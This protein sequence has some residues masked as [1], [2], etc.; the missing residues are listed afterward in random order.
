MEKMALDACILRGMDNIFYL[1]GFRGSE[2]T[3]VITRNNVILI[4]DFRYI[5]HAQQV[6]SGIEIAEMKHRKN[7]LADI[8]TERGIKTAGFDSLHM[9]YNLYRFWESSLDGVRLIPLD[10]VIEEIRVL[11]EPEEIRAIMKAISVA[12]NAFAE[13]RKKMTPGMTEKDVANELD[14]AMRNLGAERPSFPTIVASGPRAAL[15]HAEPSDKKVIAGEPIIIDFGAQVNGYCSDETC[16]VFLGEP[17]AKI[18]EIYKIVATAKNIGLSAIK[19]GVSIKAI[20]MLVREHIE[21][22]GY[23]DYFRHGV[24]HGV[25]IAVHEA[26]TINSA[27]QGELENNMV[28]TIEPGIYLPDIGGVRL[29]DMALITDEKAEVLTSLKKDTISV[30]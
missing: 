22:N 20:D 18:A 17:E 9:T 27:S 28:L 23:S 24:G 21:K 8:C 12:T 13:T 25:G 7:A 10:H 30:Q 4:T 11:K 6:T 3:L 2:G 26:P 5:T 1:T 19:S 15:P 29:E 14:Y 16:T